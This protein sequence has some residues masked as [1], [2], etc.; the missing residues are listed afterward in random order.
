MTA[1]QKWLLGT[2]RIIQL[3]TLVCEKKGTTY[4]EVACYPQTAYDLACLNRR[5]QNTQKH[6]MQQGLQTSRLH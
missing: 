3:Q 4:N 1:S 2:E 5:A 6:T